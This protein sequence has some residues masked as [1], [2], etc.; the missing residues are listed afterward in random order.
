MTIFNVRL[1]REDE[2]ELTAAAKKSGRS[3]S[4]IARDAIS[5]HLKNMADDERRW[6]T[7]QDD[8]SEYGSA[9]QDAYEA[10]VGVQV[11]KL[12]AVRKAFEARLV[13]IGNMDWEQAIEPVYEI[14][15]RKV[16]EKSGVAYAPNPYI[17][18]R[19]H[20][21]PEV[22]AV[23]GFAADDTHDFVIPLEQVFYNYCDSAGWDAFNE[24]PAVYA[25]ARARLEADDKKRV[26]PDAN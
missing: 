9:V 18:G 26:R 24:I 16:I 14:F 23:I 4:E 15:R 11:A 1:S 22:V 6:E 2:A 3:K 8:W 12:D 13:E 7:L 19:D 20:K 21:D 10:L 25:R 17:G 5:A